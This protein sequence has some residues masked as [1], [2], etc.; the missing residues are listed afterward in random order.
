[1]AGFE[2]NVLVA[3]NVNFDD[4]G[5]KPHLGI[6]TTDGQLLIGSTTLPSIKAGTLTSPGGTVS[7]GY[8]APNITLDVAGGAAIDTI[9][10][11]TGSV[12]GSTVSF[13]GN[14]TAGSTVNFIGSGTAMTFNVS[15][16]NSTIL[17]AGSG[18]ATGTNNTC[19]G[20]SAMNSVTSAN[21]NCGFGV[22]CLET[23]SSGSANNFYGV[24]SGASVS[25]GQSNCGF[26]GSTLSGVGTGSNNSALGNA[27]GSNLATSDSHNIDINNLGVSGDSNTLRIGAGTGTGT[28]ELSKAFIS[29]ING[30]TL[31][32][33]PLAVT[34]D[35]STN[36]LGVATFPS[37]GGGITTID[38]DSGSVTGATV[39]FKGATQDTTST[40]ANLA[41][42]SVEFVQNATIATEMDLYLSDLLG[43]TIL[44]LS[45]G[46]NT[47]S[48]SGNT[49]VGQV[50][51]VSLTTGSTNCAFGG[52]SLSNILDG[53][54]NVAIGA[55]A[56]A[57]CK[58]NNSNVGVGQS[59]APSLVSGD[60]NVFIGHGAAF[61]MVGGTQNVIL[62]HNAGSAYT[63]SESGNIVL[64]DSVPGIG[65]ESNVTRIGFNGLQTACFVG[66]IAGISVSGAPVLVD[67]GTGQL[68]NGIMTNT[69][70]PA[71]SAYLS[72]DQT[73][74]TGNYTIPLDTV[75]FDQASNFN[76]GTHNFT[77][78]VTGI[79]HFDMTFYA[80][81]IS[82]VTEAIIYITGIGVNQNIFDF[83]PSAT[84]DS[85]GN[86]IL[87]GGTTLALTAGDTAHLTVFI[88]T[89]T[90]TLVS[91]SNATL[92]SCY[93]VC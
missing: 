14:S 50:A 41:G 13:K 87:S 31:G 2:N 79:Y 12:T 91:G 16:L 62:G 56:L 5:P 75:A 4:A 86:L 92:L 9:D 42:A 74:V 64:G 77:A 40:G 80:N 59:V 37:G 38:G 49:V 63:A 67:S 23:L 89:G 24:A 11:D 47:L 7:I 73:G 65:G 90:L 33:T 76:T 88:P 15:T 83:N 1:M 82:A 22:F 66:G 70:Q 60:D 18:T 25:S 53:S 51:A 58:S 93:L 3:K 29:G 78:P 57:G 32:G 8:S 36:Q 21:S 72:S 34:I 85:G 27:S 52:G 48:G 46:N 71:F 19:V 43:N 39:S 30:N 45:S 68:G 81:T 61:S 84:Q 6:M 54:S 28:Q 69:A 26:G 20:V 55:G 35:S 10:G 44:G 17:G